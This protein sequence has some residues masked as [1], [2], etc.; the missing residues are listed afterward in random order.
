[1]IFT[2]DAAVVAGCLLFFVVVNLHNLLLYHAG[3]SATSQNAD[4]ERPM[5]TPLLLAIMGTAVFFFE[6]ILYIFLCFSNR[7]F[8]LSSGMTQANLESF[9]MFVMV[10][11]YAIFLWSVLARGRYATSWQMP[12]DHI[13]VDWGPYRYVRHPSYLGYFLMFI[14]FL[15]LSQSVLAL[16]SL[17]A[18]PGYALITRR[19]EEMLVSKF[20]DRYLRYQTSV[21]RF[22]PSVLVRKSARRI[23]NRIYNER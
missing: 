11:G 23:A 19:E 15:F 9:G 18:I 5:A 16:A 8:P 13:L 2:F 12:A 17:I 4:V 1:M 22:L 6:S 3:F 10:V 21:G 20:G 14:G 7:P